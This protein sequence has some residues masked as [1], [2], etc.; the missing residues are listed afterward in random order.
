MSSIEN[1]ARFIASALAPAL[2]FNAVGLLQSGLQAKYTDLFTTMRVLNAERRE[3]VAQISEAENEQRIEAI[4]TQM[5]S[6]LHRANLIRN[7]LLW[8]YGSVLLLVFAC[9]AVGA[10]A[11]GVGGMNAPIVILFSAG[12]LAIFVGLVYAFQEARVSYDVV[13]AE[14]RDMAQM[15]TVVDEHELIGAAQALSSEA[16]L[17][18]EAGHSLEEAVEP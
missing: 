16:A 15:Q 4:L 10:A 7:S 13:A 5:Q 1:A 6:L 18:E 11:E 14:V 2:L 12:L 9:F 17:R 3:K 8:L